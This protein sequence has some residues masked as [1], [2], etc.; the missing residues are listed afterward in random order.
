M[1]AHI[2][3]V[4]LFFVLCLEGSIAENRIKFFDFS[5]EYIKKLEIE[6]MGCCVTGHPIL[7]YIRKQARHVQRSKWDSS[8]DWFYKYRPKPKMLRPRL[9]E[10]VNHAH[11]KHCKRIEEEIGKKLSSND[12]SENYLASVIIRLCKTVS[13]GENYFFVLNQG[14]MPFIEVIPDGKYRFT[15]FSNL[16]GF[17]VSRSETMGE[18]KNTY[19]RITITYNLIS[20]GKGNTQ[21]SYRVTFD[22][23]GGWRNY[24][25]KPRDFELIFSR[26]YSRFTLE[27]QDSC[28]D[29]ILNSLKQHPKIFEKVN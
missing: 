9:R 27:Q 8:P 12:F 11:F 3:F 26:K 13:G 22:C 24:F 25:S 10:D 5:P 4:L 20:V 21:A 15:F 23:D 16:L 14:G 18:A 29:I 1:R 2:I 19:L 6:E 7:N 17:P 28:E